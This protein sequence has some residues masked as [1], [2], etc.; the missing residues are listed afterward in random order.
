MTPF[1]GAVIKNAQA[2]AGARVTMFIQNRLA[3]EVHFRHG[4]FSE[5]NVNFQ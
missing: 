5:M 1:L 4:Y 2:F 3:R